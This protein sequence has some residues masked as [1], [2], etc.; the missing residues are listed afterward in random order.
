MTCSKDAPARRIFPG[1]G[2]KQRMRPVLAAAAVLTALLASDARAATVSSLSVNSDARDFIGDGVPRLAH[3]GGPAVSAAPDPYGD[4]GLAAGAVTGDEGV[5]VEI[6]PPPG[7]TLR[8]HNWT[9]TDRYPFQEGDRPGLTVQAGSR[10]CNVATGSLEVLDVGFDA[11]GAVNRL[12]ALFDHHCEGARSSAFGEVRWRAWVPEAAAHV[13]P[14]VLRWPVLDSFWPAAPATVV[15][16]GSAPA[17]RVALAGEDAAHFSVRADGCT[18]RTPPCAVEL[19]FA[20]TAPGARRARLEIADSAGVRHAVTLEGFLHGG[21][22]RADIEVLAG[23]VAA[24]PEDQGL[25]AYGPADA[26]FYGVEY[27]PNPI[28]ALFLQSNADWREWW[29][30]DAYAGGG[31]KLQA[32]ASYPDA[33]G[34]PYGPGPGI[35]VSGGPAWC[36]QTAGAFTVHSIDY[37][38]D[39]R[40]RSFDTTFERR[41]YPDE[42]PAARGRWRF[43]A[44]DDAPLPAWM[45]PGPRPWLDVPVAQQGPGS[46]VSG[47]LPKG[48]RRAAAARVRLGTRRADRLRGTRRADLIRGRAGNDRIYARAGADCVLGGRGADLLVGGRGRDLLDCGR[49]RRDRVVAGRRDRVRNCERR[50]R[51]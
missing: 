32:G 17:T 51:P 40:L 19:G 18:G 11:Q 6:A 7:E 27:S 35:R 2:Y 10:G 12:W 33:Q 3:P 21:T 29:S 28:V 14:G 30:V 22:T 1:G 43:R 42:R 48:C 4:G 44:G 47:S 39:G 50:R 8:P 25:H 16:H 49:G 9:R 38:P 26:V 23:D 34:D 20:P 46:G 15:Y 36:N 41:C 24:P 37:L 31:Q 45:V 13:T 5:G